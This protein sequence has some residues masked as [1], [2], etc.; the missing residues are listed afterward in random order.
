MDK[1]RSD[2]QEGSISVRRMHLIMMA[3]AF[4]LAILLLYA[5]NSVMTGYR[6]LQNA[7]DQYIE[8]QQDTQDMM[9]A[10]DYLTDRVRCFVVTGNKKYVDDF[11]EEVNETRRRDAALESMETVLAGT[12]TY[13]YLE[14]A[15]WYS[16]NLL[17]IEHYAMRLAAEV[18][19]LD[20]SGFPEEIQN[21]TI[22]PRHAWRNTESKRNI[23]IDLVFNSEYEKY[24]NNIRRDVDLCSEALVQNAKESQQ[25]S[26]AHLLTVIRRLTA[27]IILLLLS[28]LFMVILTARLIID[29]LYNGI[30]HIKKKE[31]FPE[32]GSSEMRY[33]AKT[34]ND[35][36]ESSRR[37][38]ETL[39]YE[40]SHDALT[41]LS[42]RAMFEK[43]RKECDPQSTAMILIDIDFFK[44]VNDTYGH[45]AGDQL[46]KRAAKVFRSSF[47][48]EDCVCRI[49]GDEFA[50]LM[51]NSGS[52][53]R[54]LVQRK[55]ET[56]QSRLRDEE[57][58]VPGVTIS[59]G[60]AFPD[61]PNPTG[62]IYQDADTALYKVKNAGRNGLA[63]YE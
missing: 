46:L 12:E 6:I 37:E 25:E 50:V 3:A 63:F 59:V 9:A 39:S 16:N 1:N 30:Q 20:V 11:F 44:E 51:M 22:R 38:Q 27:C 14:E 33:L 52:H 10:S 19:G 43:V 47:R 7:T 29:P 57:N 40:A 21:V 17:N 56:A 31:L 18:Y 36:Y 32:A 24:K 55:I 49:G 60:V 41:G 35:L 4:L 61:R 2:R 45:E 15:L 58:G 26:S 13:R 48:S 8:L 62:D 53:L 42:N 34:Y 54:A 28:V 5:T 23:A